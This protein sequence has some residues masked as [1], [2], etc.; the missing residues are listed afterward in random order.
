MFVTKK[1]VPWSLSYIKYALALRCNVI[2]LAD[3]GGRIKFSLQALLILAKFNTKR[4]Q[5]ELPVSFLM[6]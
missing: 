1:L 4:I 6:A 2:L 3:Q 5:I